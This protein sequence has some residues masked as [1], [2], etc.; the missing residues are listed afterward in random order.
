M[1]RLP[2]IKKNIKV[3]KNNF[4]C[5][6]INPILSFRNK[7][8]IKSN[9]IEVIDLA[10]SINLSVKNCKNIRIR[11]IVPSTFFG[12]GQIGNIKIKLKKNF[13]ELL[14]IN[15]QISPTQQR[16]LEISLNCKVL[17]RTALI[18]EIFG[19]RAVTKQGKLQVEMASLM[20]QKTRLVRSWTHLER[21]RGGHGFMGGPGERQIES[22]KRQINKRIYKLKIELKKIE[23]NKNIQRRFRNKSLNPFVSLVGYTNAGKS[24]LFNFLVNESVF[25]KDQLFATLDTTMRKWRLSNNNFA[26]L[27]DTVGFISNLP[28]ELIE[29]FKTTL[30]E[31]NF[32]DYILNVIDISNPDWEKQ[33]KI[34]ENILVSILKDN[35]DE[36][37]IIEI[38]NKVDLLD[39]DELIYFNNA[40]NRKENIILFSSKIKTGRKN[41][42]N[43]INKKLINNKKFYLFNFSGSTNGKK[44]KSLSSPVKGVIF[45]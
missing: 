40:A 30:D 39:K 44:I 23:S 24:T 14:V 45:L 1:S 5:I 20:Y 7:N 8:L 28:T 13:S 34:V 9:I 22:D 17:D 18:L 42:I 25:V 43:L 10:K 21:Q 36:N 41:L 27:S 2:R 16:N 31:I 26:I 38:W 33:K 29:S 19:K 15:Y 37:K 3:F 6:V 12:K 4:N 35:Y 11:K 32:S